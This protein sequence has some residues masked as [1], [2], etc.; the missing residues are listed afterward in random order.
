MVVFTSE[1]PGIPRKS[2]FEK[3]TKDEGKKNKFYCL[4]LTSLACH[5]AAGALRESDLLS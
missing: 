2:D 1:N 4:P 3:K 5:S